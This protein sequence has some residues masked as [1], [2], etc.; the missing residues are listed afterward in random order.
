[1]SWAEVT[2][3]VTGEGFHCTARASLKQCACFGG[4][5]FHLH[6]RMT[7]QFLHSILLFM[8]SFNGVTSYDNYHYFGSNFPSE[9]ALTQINASQCHFFFFFFMEQPHW[10]LTAGNLNWSS[11]R[12]YNDCSWWLI[13]SDL[14]FNSKVNFNLAIGNGKV[15]GR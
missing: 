10:N 7:L 11:D 6:R 14:V 5:Q 2:L 9:A 15:V 13:L 12:K 8:F 1:M 4:A 3:L